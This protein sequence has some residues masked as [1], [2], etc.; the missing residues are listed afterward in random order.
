MAIGSGR[1][2]ISC[3][4]PTVWHENASASAIAIEVS[5]V[6]LHRGA[7][8]KHHY[9]PPYRTGVELAIGGIK[10]N[11]PRATECIHSGRSAHQDARCAI[12]V[13]AS[14]EVLSDA[15]RRSS[16]PGGLG[17]REAVAASNALHERTGRWAG[18]GSLMRTAPLALAYLY[19]H[20]EKIVNLPR[21]R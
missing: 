9:R 7:Q 8:L 17:A 3:R 6:P 19:K 10:F 13:C 16:T 4:D 18:N 15:E 1:C 12:Y 14:R 11:I 21:F 2:P 5:S 20:N